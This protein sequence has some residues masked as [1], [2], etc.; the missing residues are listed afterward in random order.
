MKRRSLDGMHRLLPAAALALATNTTLDFGIAGVQK[1]GT[2][3][4]AEL[5]RAHGACVG[6]HE[7][8]FFSHA[9]SGPEPRWRT[10][11]DRATRACAAA[12]P[13]GFD[14]PAFSFYGA[15][16]PAEVAGFAA[17]APGLRLVLVLREPIQR[18]RSQH[19]MMAAGAKSRR[20][21]RG[22]P[23]EVLARDELA[24]NGTR[25]PYDVVRRGLYHEQVEALAGFDLHVAV[26]ERLFAGGYGA[27]FR[28]VGLEPPATYV[29]VFRRQTKVPSALSPAALELLA[30][31]YRG[32]TDRLYGAIG[33]VPE[34]ERWYADRGLP[35]TRVRR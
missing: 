14:D 15:G 7:V 27:V 5:L 12:Q 17:L 30:A 26:A 1:G 20:V 28:F 21:L 9:R 16:A 31:A 18:A 19:G 4:L 6:P 2:T 29:D 8:H 33:V 25:D 24:R 13:R 10:V 32:P 11:H 3:A 23:L 34:W 35:A 22:R